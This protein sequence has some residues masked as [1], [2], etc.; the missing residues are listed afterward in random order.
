MTI[1]TDPNPTSVVH[2]SPLVYT[3]SDDGVWIEC[4]CG[5]HVNLGFFS[6]VEDAASQWNLH[7]PTA[8]AEDNDGS[9]QDHSPT[10]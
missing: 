8:A 6:S 5:W 1:D 9:E 3:N 10:C 4:T 2:E 7:A